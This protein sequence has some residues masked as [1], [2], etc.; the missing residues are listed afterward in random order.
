MTVFYV[1]KVYKDKYYQYDLAI[2]NV[3]NLDYYLLYPPK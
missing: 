2:K 3:I 1:C